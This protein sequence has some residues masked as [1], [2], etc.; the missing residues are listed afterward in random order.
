METL[1]AR[2]DRA[3]PL[4]TAEAVILAARLARALEPH[5]E[6][7]EA[8]GAVSPESLMLGRDERAP[9][10]L[11]AA[12]RSTPSFH[13]QSPERLAG[14]DASPEDDT[15]A[16]GSTL[17]VALTGTVPFPGDTAAE[18]LA[19]IEQGSI[20]PL[21]VFDAGDDDLQELVQ[22]IFQR[23][24]EERTQSV[25]RVRKS[26]AR[27]LA[28]RGIAAG[29]PIE[30][31]RGES[32]QEL[33]LS[34]IPPPP[35]LPEVED[36]PTI[37]RAA[38]ASGVLYTF[39]DEDT[40]LPKDA[41]PVSMPPSSGQ[42][43]ANAPLSSRL[44]P[45]SELLARA[46]AAPSKMPAPA[47]PGMLKPA[48]L[49]TRLRSPSIPP[50]GPRLNPPKVARERAAKALS[51]RPPPVSAGTEETAALRAPG[52]P[53]DLLPAETADAAPSSTPP[54]LPVASRTP[55]KR[56]S[57]P[58][59]PVESSPPSA[60]K[61]ST[62]PPLPPSTPPPST[63]PSAPPSE[64]RRSKPPR[65]RAAK[66]GRKATAKK[67]PA[68][69]AAS[70]SAE[71]PSTEP[72]S[73]K[74]A[75][76]KVALVAGAAVLLFAGYEALSS[77]GGSTPAPDASSAPTT[78]AAPLASV[79]A[80]A[81]VAPPPPTTHEILASASAPAPSASS[82]P[83]APATSALPSSSVVAPSA[84]QED[85]GACVV[86]LFPPDSFAE[87][88][89]PKFDFVCRE[90]D[91]RL[92]AQKVHEVLV[93]AGM[94]R[95]VSDGMRE[96]AVMGWYELAAFAALRGRCC[97]DPRPLELP[98]SPGSC[99]SM[100]DA[101]NGVS[102]GARAGATEAQQSDALSA[103]RKSLSCTIKSGKAK[104]FGAY[105]RPAGG[106]DTAFL[107]TYQRTRSP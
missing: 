96:W 92:G 11:R 32:A 74:S 70:V 40:T 87:G 45:T 44:P 27:W 20:A 103:F 31:G 77:G 88:K 41:G 104:P 47:T 89:S 105:P 35:A 37:P 17:Y 4:D 58:P 15:W 24:R 5:H 51:E 107:K 99:P 14:A 90:N 12:S 84:P 61:R 46:K 65:D 81:S 2:I 43:D 49:A 34:S 23:S 1:A 9:V 95:T 62:P 94:G 7:G 22:S 50:S 55:S 19:R 53:K 106:E 10:V 80:A 18:V 54:P 93:R 25:V 16:V 83:S 85:V 13:H 86:K 98:P 82:A 79:A 101:L 57:P 56:P 39:A 75:F 69:P 42:R 36:R 60:P 26:L 91:P 52:V 78:S 38:S 100:Q 30:I 73:P 72:A 67:D 97:P 68:P 29:P 102:K 28:K 6:R 76:T 64:E 8:H 59:L 3:G 33:D 48:E 71:A 66:P 63:P 21:A